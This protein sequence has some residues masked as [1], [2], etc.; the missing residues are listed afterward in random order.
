MKD[1]KME[2]VTTE[3]G[4]SLGWCVFVEEDV[5]GCDEVAFGE[6]EGHGCCGIVLEV[7]DKH[8]NAAVGP[9]QR[10]LYFCEAVREGLFGW[11]WRKEGRGKGFE[12][13]VGIGDWGEMGGGD[14]VGR[15]LGA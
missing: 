13:V 2:A 3:E 10:V 14:W 12:V 9:E 7:N 15:G 5:C 6:D 1:L 8:T 4:Y 11:W